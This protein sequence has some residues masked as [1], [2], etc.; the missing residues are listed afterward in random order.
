MTSVSAPT[1][2]Q[3]EAAETATAAGAAT[4]AGTAEAPGIPAQAAAPRGL[5]L[6]VQLPLPW[7]IPVRRALDDALGGEPGIEIVDVP[8]TGIR[9]AGRGSC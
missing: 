8:A 6:G 1:P 4:V 3:A 7:G 2:H 5:V 9:T